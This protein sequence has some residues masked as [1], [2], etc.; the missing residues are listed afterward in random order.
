MAGVVEGGHGVNQALYHVAFVIERELYRHG[1]PGIAFIR[2]SPG[3]KYSFPAGP[4]EVGEVQLHQAVA[5]DEGQANTIHGNK[6]KLRD[7]HAVAL[8]KATGA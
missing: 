6:K 5:E 1:R 8:V 7:C 4:V 3:C 2:Y